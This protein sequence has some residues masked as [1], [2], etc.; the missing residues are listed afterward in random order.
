M[1]GSVVTADSLA[2]DTVESEWVTNQLVIRYL[3][4]SGVPI[5]GEPVRVTIDQSVVAEGADIQ[6]V[7]GVEIEHYVVSRT[8]GGDLVQEPPFPALDHG[9]LRFDHAG[10][11]VGKPVDGHFSVIFA[12]GSNLDGT[13]TTWLSAPG[14]SG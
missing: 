13:F 4:S 7:P 6:A 5:P 11:D 8:I 3:S 14:S 10:T 1:T 9:T 2:F 12:D